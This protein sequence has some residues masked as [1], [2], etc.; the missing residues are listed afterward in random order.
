MDNI[1]VS[2]QESQ[3]RKASEE[4]PSV[5]TKVVNTVDEMFKNP[6]S[7]K[8]NEQKGQDSW[9]SDMW[10]TITSPVVSLN[11]NNYNYGVQS[12]QTQKPKNDDFD[13]FGDFSSAT[14]DLK[15][16]ETKG[17]Q[18]TIA[19]PPANSK[20]IVSKLTAPLKTVVPA[21]KEAIK[22]LQPTGNFSI[23]DLVVDAP[24]VSHKTQ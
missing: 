7:S 12:Q 2:R 6:F 10:N 15:S 5:F 16:Q 3:Q 21:V 23:F 8:G 19:K 24:V 11:F 22:S 9:A 14:S 1:D 18:K 13:I 20:P 17:I 4:K